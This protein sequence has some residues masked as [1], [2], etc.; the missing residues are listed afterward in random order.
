M[1]DFLKGSELGKQPHC[2]HGDEY[3]TE[4]SRGSDLSDITE[5]DEEEL[6]SEMQLEDGGRRRPGGPS[7]G[8]LKV[9]AES[10]SCCAWRSWGW[11][12]VAPLPSWSM[13][14]RQRVLTPGSSRWD[15]LGAPSCALG[16]QERSLHKSWRPSRGLAGSVPLLAGA[17]ALSQEVW[18]SCP[19]ARGR[20]AW[21]QRGQDRWLGSPLWASWMSSICKQLWAQVQLCTLAWPLSTLR[22]T[23]VRRGHL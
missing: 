7:H 3:P 2:C 23:H 8:T 6:R 21:A 9:S 19:P 14:R 5:E 4:S 18:L 15:R 17:A 10:C 20:P 11:G 16:L 1:D 13:E 12:L 22:R